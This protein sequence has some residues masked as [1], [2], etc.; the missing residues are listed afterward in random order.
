MNNRC[1][2]I[3]LSAMAIA[4]L[5]GFLSLFYLQI[6]AAEITIDGASVRV[7]TD[8]YRV[9]FD[10]GVISEVYNKRTAELYTSPN[11]GSI[12]SET[13]ILRSRHGPIWAS[14]S[15]IEV[16][17][18]SQASA[19]MAFRRGENEII[20]TIDVEAGTGDLL[21]GGNGT[22]D[23]GGVYGF[24]WGCDNIDINS[25]DLILPAR[26]GQVI[27]ASSPFE[28]ERYRYPALWEVQLA[29]LQGERGGFFVRGT[30]KTFQA[31]YF[32]YQK[33]SEEIALGF[34]THNQA[35][36]DSLTRVESARWRFNTYAGDYR[37]PAS[38][39]RHWME[40]AF[41]PWRL[42]EV[43]SWVEDIGLVIITGQFYHLEAL[44]QLAEQIDPSKTLLY[45]NNWR[46]DIYDRNYPDYTPR[47]GFGDFVKAVH[48][49]GYRVMLHVN[50]VGVA[51]DH[52]LYSEFKQ[53][54]FRGPRDGDLIGT[55]WHNPAAP[56]RYA[57]IN[58]AS[59]KFRDLLVSRFQEVWKEYRVDAFHLDISHAVIND[60]NG[61]IE[62]LNSGQGNVLMHKEL[63]E[64][65]PG[66]VFS[67]E[68]LHEV[69]F[70]RESF[71]QRW[72]LLPGSTPHPIS[73]FLFS[74][75]TRPYGYLG[76]PVLSRDASGYYMFLDS[77]ENWGVL[78]TLWIWDLQRQPYDPLTQQILSIARQWQELGLRPDFESDWGSD[79]LFQY[80]TEN[81]ET[82][83]Y[84]DT[85]AGS[86]LR[87]PEHSGFERVYGVTQVD[88]T[89]G[90]PDWPAYNETSL[91][92]LD[93]NR[94][95]ILSDTP[96]DL[97]RVHVNSLP[98]DVTLTESRVTE[99]FALFR[100]ERSE[101]ASQPNP[102]IGIG[103]FLPTEPLDSNPVSLQ[104]IGQGQYTLETDTSSQPVIIFLA[105]PQPVSPP[106][107]LRD[108]QFTKGLQD[109]VLFHPP[110]DGEYGHFARGNR[111]MNGINKDTINAHPSPDKPIV[112]SFLLQLPQKPKLRFTFSMGL[113]EGCSQGVTFRV[114]LNGETRLEHFKDTFDWTEGSVSLGDFAGK[115]LLLELVTDPAQSGDSGANCDWASWADLHITAAPNPDANL[116]GQVNVLDLITVAQSFGQ[117]P[118]SNPQADTNKD[119]VVN[120]L[121]LVFVAEHLSQN[122]AAPSQLDR[123]KSIP[124]IVKEVIAAQ[125]A[126]GEL[127]AIPNKTPRVQLAIEL[128][129]HYLAVAD[130]SVRET[131][132]LPNYPNPFNPD[133]WIPYQLTE[134]SGVTVKIY[135]IRGHLVRTIEVG[136]K[137]VGYYLTREK[138]VYW[139]GRNEIGE[140]VSSG[141]YFYTLNAGD[142]TKT[143]RMVIVK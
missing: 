24:Q 109:G 4:I 37:V 86:A 79:T 108:A 51:S 57:W 142:Y 73:A 107:D 42:S 85:H 62:G 97:S 30:D 69:S 8:A 23:T 138:A 17:K 70:V 65:M 35:P 15:A 10:H 121:D 116:D 110:R 59:S 100:F 132:L 93:P 143:R 131:K 89:L 130:R 52:P 118:P 99:N 53:Y 139:D 5:S 136:H 111:T 95:Y 28:S 105:P 63:A 124:S 122:A 55:G 77:Y 49:I 50:L 45:L 112:G 54:Q 98:V 29:V 92:G 66:V 1:L 128:L 113:K 91:L 20:L 9:Q 87:L 129:R 94:Y 2:R 22:A 38:I 16:R 80:I 140:P 117:Q 114:L 40:E 41:E 133:T 141:V 76:I 135:D 88:T 106:Y 3:Q 7:D 39:Y 25:V 84:Q 34:E 36:W 14:Q 78:P 72:K 90:I 71:A 47:E 43:P 134:D 83:I 104:G 126:L 58:S 6:A 11:R 31:K 115:P 60:G 127:E 48:D 102:S 21:I 46:K 96:R 74:R 18:N 13:G 101:M 64:A 61:L 120:L 82:V 68:H 12:R 56:H 67:G 33:N 137:P 32:G 103:F 81:G 44:S 125:R 19:T 27:M 26:G 123:I 119:G 75:Y